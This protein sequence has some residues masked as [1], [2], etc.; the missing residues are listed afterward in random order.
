VEVTSENRDKASLDIF[1]IRDESLK[2]CEQGVQELV[3]EFESALE[4]FRENRDRF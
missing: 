1:W 2:E 3:E 4:R